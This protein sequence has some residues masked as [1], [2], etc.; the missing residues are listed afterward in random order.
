MA[1]L[2][3]L[4]DECIEKFNEDIKDPNSIFQKINKVFDFLPL[5]ALV[6][7]KILCVHGFIG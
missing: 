4:G 3:G 1:K 2:F 7:E 6:E 5:A